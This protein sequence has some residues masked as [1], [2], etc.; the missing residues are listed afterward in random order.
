MKTPTRNHRRAMG[1]HLLGLDDAESMKM[2]L[3][4]ILIRSNKV[5]KAIFLFNKRQNVLAQVDRNDSLSH[6][7]LFSG[8]RATVLSMGLLNWAAAKRGFTRG[9]VNRIQGV[10]PGKSRETLSHMAINRPAASPADSIF[11]TRTKKS[12]K[13]H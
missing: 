1:F 10:A 4:S 13:A 2:P 5:K 9:M 7:H 6:S 11:R 12:K 3:R 8:S